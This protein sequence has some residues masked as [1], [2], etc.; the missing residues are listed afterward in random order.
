[1]LTISCH[2]KLSK[3]R[4]ILYYQCEPIPQVLIEESGNDSKRIKKKKIMVQTQTRKML[5]KQKEKKYVIK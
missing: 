1:M 5:S 4:I 3:I 2:N